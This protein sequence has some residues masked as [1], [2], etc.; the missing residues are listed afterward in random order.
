LKLAGSGPQ[1]GL[2]INHLLLNTTLAPR[3]TAAGIDREV[4]EWE[5]SDHAPV[6]ISSSRPLVGGP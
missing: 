1:P 2:H 3:L 5:K 4:R 6:W